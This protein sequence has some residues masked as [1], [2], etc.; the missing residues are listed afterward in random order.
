MFNCFLLEIIPVGKAYKE[1]REKKIKNKNSLSK[2]FL[3][4]TM[5]LNP[6]PFE[7]CLWTTRKWALTFF[8]KKLPPFYLPL[9]RFCVTQHQPLT[10]CLGFALRM[11]GF[12]NFPPFDSI[13]LPF[14]PFLM[15]AIRPSRIL[16]LNLLQNYLHEN[17]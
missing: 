13:F 15:A 5:I 9:S 17:G 4:I 3:Q 6:L 2:V 11:H 8:P 1:K 7:V 10:S 12:S 16:A 14:Q